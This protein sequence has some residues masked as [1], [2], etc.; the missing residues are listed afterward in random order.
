MHQ[1]RVWAGLL[2][3][4]MLTRSRGVPGALVVELA[5]LFKCVCSGAL[6]ASTGEQ[7]KMPEKI[8]GV[9]NGSCP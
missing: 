4:R 2:Y 3:A 8:E 5:D 1:A 6:C 7:D 9:Y